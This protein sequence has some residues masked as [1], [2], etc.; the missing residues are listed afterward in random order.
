MLTP[1][2]QRIQQRLVGRDGVIMQAQEDR[3]PCLRELV[4][5]A[6]DEARGKGANE[7]EELVGLLV[8]ESVGIDGFGGFEGADLEVRSR[9]GERFEVFYEF[10]IWTASVDGI[11]YRESE[12]VEGER[13][14]GGTYSSLKQ[15]R[16]ATSW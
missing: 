8:V 12:E 3:H 15:R 4:V 6:R 9:G 1:L 5:A 11:E 10:V 13:R 14:L 16:R 2:A 7:E